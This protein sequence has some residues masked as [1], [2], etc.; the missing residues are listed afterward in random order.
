M[1]NLS[2]ESL[3]AKVAA[4]PFWYHRIELPGGV[5]T[6]GTNPLLPERYRVPEDLTGKRVLDIGAWDGY[7]TFEALR[8]N[9]ALVVAI[10]DFSDYLGHLRTEDRKAWQTFDFCRDALGYSE[11]RCRRLEISIYEITPEKLG[12]YFDVVLFFGTLYHLRHPLLG[13]DKIAQVMNP[14]GELCVE[15]TILD[16]FS[17]YQGGFGHGYPGRQ[18]VSEFYP[19]NEYAGNAT[20]WFNPTLH[21]LAAWLVAAGFE[22]VQGWKLT[23]KP[24]NVGFCRGFAKGFRRPN[25]PAASVNVPSPPRL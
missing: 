9:A 17:P 5:T 11:P 13:L 25:F 24:A 20:N 19:T 16:D 15:T 12:G 14:G 1:T 23:E 3:N 8:R 22:R 10:D 18:V 4:F 7:W 21:C 6:P 2:P